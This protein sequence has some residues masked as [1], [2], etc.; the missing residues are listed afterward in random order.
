M[1]TCECCNAEASGAEE[2]CAACGE[3][4]WKPA[5]AEPKAE[6]AERVDPRERKGKR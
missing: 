3:A 4:S 2:T 1:K 5:E 6:P